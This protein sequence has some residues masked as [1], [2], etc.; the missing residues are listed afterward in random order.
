MTTIYGPIVSFLLSLYL[1]SGFQV[2]ERVNMSLRSIVPIIAESSLSGQA[3]VANGNLV[4]DASSPI[5]AR[6]I[7]NVYST[8]QIQDSDIGSVDDLSHK[9]IFQAIS[10]RNETMAFHSKTPNAWVTSPPS[11]T[12]LTRDF[13]FSAKV[14]IPDQPIVYIPTIG[15][16]LKFGWIQVRFFFLSLC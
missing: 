10:S 16:V 4:L 5:P 6:G 11:L 1:F 2:D 15:E 14:S 7:R 13:V 12:Q 9:N 8:Y 3:V